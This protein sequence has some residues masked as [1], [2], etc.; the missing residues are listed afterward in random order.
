LTNKGN[1][2]LKEI[3]FVTGKGGVGK[4]T[5]SYWLAN[6]FAKSGKKTLLV[7]IG[8][9]SF[10]SHFLS[11]PIHYQ[12]TQVAPQ[13]EVAHWS[14]QECLKSYA[15]SLLKVE[16]LYRLFF[17]NPV[18]RSLIQVAPSLAEL[19][20]TGQ[21]TSAP[22]NHGPHGDHEILVIDAYASGHFLSLIKAPEAMGETI[23]LGPMG[24]QSRE[25][26]KIFKDSGLCHLHIVTTSE[27]LPVSEAAELKNEVS[28]SFSW[29]VSFILNRFVE[30]HLDIEK[31]NLS[32]RSLMQKAILDKLV[33]QKTALQILKKTNCPIR[34]LPLVVSLKGPEDLNGLKEVKI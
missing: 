17:E 12:P 3:H 8:D 6:E 21:I 1:S 10:F 11:Q 13:F 2:S 22:R 28:K 19:S 34:N 18:T 32:Q 23:Q 16:A 20:V 24:E 7:E 26:H 9:R 5:A 15:L 4:S 25:I 31:V 14:A 30:T 27:E 33:S 29:P